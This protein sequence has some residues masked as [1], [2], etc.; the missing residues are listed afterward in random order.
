MNTTNAEYIASTES[1]IPDEDFINEILD[2][3]CIRSCV[4]L[5]ESSFNSLVDVVR[6]VAEKLATEKN[7]DFVREFVSLCEK[8]LGGVVIL[9]ALGMD[10][11]EYSAI[12]RT[13]GVSKQA[14]HKRVVHLREIF[15]IPDV[16]NSPDEVEQSDFLK[17]LSTTTSSRGQSR[18]GRFCEN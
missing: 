11:R 13:F 6:Q 12:A 1:A 10:D 17:V 5:S 14:V 3:W 7:I 2:E 9:K 16:D 4:Q 18:V 15:K 8:D